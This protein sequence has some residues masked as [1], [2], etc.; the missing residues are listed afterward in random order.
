MAVD[1]TEEQIAAEKEK[2]DNASETALQLSRGP[3][4]IAERY[5]TFDSLELEETFGNKIDRKGYFIVTFDK[6]EGGKGFYLKLPFKVSVANALLAEKPFN[7]D[8]V[9]VPTLKN[10][11]IDKKDP[12][13]IKM[14]VNSVFKASRAS[15]YHYGALN[16][17]TFHKNASPAEIIKKINNEWL[18]P[19]QGIQ[20]EEIPGSIQINWELV[21]KKAI[22]TGLLIIGAALIGWGLWGLRYFRKEK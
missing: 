15:L 19:A 22:N 12:Y 6:I 1:A 20:E 5:N 4:G 8:I 2:R 17:M 13:Q 9:L 11:N 16:S 7:V 21:R 14:M 10:E 18:L 3:S